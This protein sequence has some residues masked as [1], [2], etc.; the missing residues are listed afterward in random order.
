MVSGTPHS[1][2]TSVSID[3]WILTYIV[4]YGGSEYDA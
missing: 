1:K 2:E 3:S 4:D